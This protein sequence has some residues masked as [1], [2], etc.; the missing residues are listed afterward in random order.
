MKK[1][2]IKFNSKFFLTNIIFI[3]P[4][5]FFTIQIIISI[6]KIFHSPFDNQNKFYY[7]VIIVCLFLIILFILALLY[8]NKE[9]KIGFSFPKENNFEMKI[10]HIHVA[11][12]I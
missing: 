2:V 4:I 12:H 11:T 8:L 5:I 3:L 10:N 7:F 6:Y 9:L 1:T